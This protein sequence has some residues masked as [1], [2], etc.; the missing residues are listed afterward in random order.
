MIFIWYIIKTEKIRT[1]TGRCCNS[2]DHQQ[3]A[4][5]N[6]SSSITVRASH[7]FLIRWRASFTIK[8]DNHVKNDLI[9]QHF[10]EPNQTKFNN[11]AF[12]PGYTLS[13]ADCFHCVLMR[14]KGWQT[15]E[16]SSR[17][18]LA[19]AFWLLIYLISSNRWVIEIHQKFLSVHSPLVSVGF[20]HLLGLHYRGSSLGPSHS[21]QWQ[22]ISHWDN[23]PQDT[24]WS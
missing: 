24:V 23:Q 3:M 19:N 6:K 12:G 13:I 7:P 20:Q 5:Y 22:S 15:T 18:I 1:R 17:A 2:L 21:S 10:I 8:H 4:A 9:Y 16:V 14:N 11:S